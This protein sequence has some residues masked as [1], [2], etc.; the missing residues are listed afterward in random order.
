MNI[1]IVTQYFWPE[2]FRIND[3]AT[4]L[5]ERGHTVTVLTGKPNYPSGKFFPGYGFLGRAREI[6]GQITVHRVPLFPRGQGAWRLALNYFSFAISATLLGPWRCRD[7]YDAILVYEPSPI[8]VGLP[9]LWLKRLR[10]APVFFWVQDL[11]PESLSATGTVRSPVILRWV[12]RMV[13]FIY[14]GCDRILIQSRAFRQ[15]IESMGVASERILYFPNSAEDHYRPVSIDYIARKDAGWPEGFVVLFAGNIGAAQDFDTIVHAAELL[16]AQRD[17]HWVIVG[18]GRMRAWV[19]HTVAE[20]GLASNFHMFGQHP[21]ESMPRYFS[22]AD[23]MLVTLRREPI[24]A[25]TIPS[26]IQSYLASSRPI[27]AALDGEGAAVITEAGAG[28]T[29]SAEDPVALAQA[30]LKMAQMVPDER[31]DMGVKGRRYF[32]ENFQRDM[33][34]GRLLDWLQR[35]NTEAAS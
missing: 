12:G 21:V 7:H 26:K 9:A 30:V 16:K 10:R 24:F 35:G 13:R 3:L 27:V 6:Y 32:E 15:S 1:L 8:T 14:R 2:N 25:L 20:R 22:M 18:D 5:A 29:V 17:I 4:G 11:W 23:V 33:L 19:E 34:I 28:L 31:D